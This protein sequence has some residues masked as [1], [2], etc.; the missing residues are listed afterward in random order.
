MTGEDMIIERKHGKLDVSSSEAVIAAAHIGGYATLH[1]VGRDDCGNLTCYS[2]DGKE[3]I[4]PAEELSSEIK[5]KGQFT[6][7]AYR[8]VGK[9]IR[10]KMIT[11]GILSTASRKAIQED[12]RKYIINE[13]RPGEV[14]PCCVVATSVHGV[15]VDVGNGLV[16]LIGE[17]RI[18]CS[19]RK[20]KR[21]DFR[22][23]DELTAVYHKNDD[24]RINLSLREVVGTWAESAAQF[25]AE[26]VALG[27]VSGMCKDGI[28]IEL[29]PN[30]QGLMDYPSGVEL[31]VGAAVYVEIRTIDYNRCRVRLFYDYKANREAGRVKRPPASVWYRSRLPLGTTHLNYWE[32]LC[33]ETKDGKVLR[34]STRFE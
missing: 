15:F 4:V 10:V 30:L 25:R 32:H 27:I 29:A 1:C 17:R 2:S 14:M 13:L 19:T 9:D 16:C 31:S 7:E 33:K 18:S 21:M 20:G 6:S 26:S 23:G 28:F 24:G 22:A 8:C 12:T 11:Q 5:G 3:F 34:V